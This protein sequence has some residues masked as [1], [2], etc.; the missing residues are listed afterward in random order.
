MKINPGHARVR[1]RAGS[2][3]SAVRLRALFWVPLVYPFQVMPDA[4]KRPPLP[5]LC[6]DLQ[7]WVSGWYGTMTCV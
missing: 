5:V 4:D 6:L 2:P 3:L 1:P 7:P